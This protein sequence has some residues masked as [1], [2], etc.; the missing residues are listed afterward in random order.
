M[1]PPLIAHVVQ[2]F[3]MGGLEN[4][5]VNLLNHMPAD[6]YRHAVVCL[7]GYTDFRHRLRRN[8]VQFFALHK[9]PGKDPKLYGRLFRLLR[10]LHPD[11]L[12]TRNLSTLEGQFVAAAA[13]VRARVHGEH[14]RDVFDLHG[15]NVK[16]NLL[17]KMARPLVGHY[18]ALSRDLATWL[19][20]TVGVDAKRIA[21]IYN[22]VD[23]V[24][25]HPRGEERKPIGPAG[26]M[27][28]NELLIGSVGRMAEVKDYPNLVR[29]FLRLLELSPE[30]RSRARLVILGEGTARAECLAL[31][32]QANAEQLAWLP[33]SRDDIADLMR[34]FDVFTLSSLGEGISNT[35]LEAMACGLPVIATSVGG[36]T[37]LVVDGITGTLVPP[38]APEAMAQALLTYFEDNALARKHGTAGREKIEAQFSM[39]AMVR[40]YMGVYDA[41]L[42]R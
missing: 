31:L 9:Q 19:E 37:E 33:G 8:D 21:Q 16:Y 34:Q 14:G 32:K 1:R 4:G 13:G 12:H 29:A 2:H 38:A 23:S 40:G 24:R 39:E 20:H 11:L 26:F 3:G 27:S 17:R 7:D 10:E 36:N 25:F 6:R 5:V 35:I 15:K 28:G 30:A 41:V 42:A 22:G 18:I